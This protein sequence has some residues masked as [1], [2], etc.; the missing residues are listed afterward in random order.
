[1]SRTAPS[2][3]QVDPSAPGNIIRIALA[4]ESVLTVGISAYYIFFPR[5]YLL[6]TLGTAS[7]QVTTTALQMTQQFGAVGVLT[8]AGVGL[9]VPNTKS[10]IELRQPLYRALLAFE[11]AFVPLLL[12]QGFMM[13]DGIPKDSM[14]STA[15]QFVPFVAWRIFTLGWKPEWFGRYLDGKKSE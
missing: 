12:W 11:L 9:F 1:M 8:G 13:A 7:A 14:V 15:L 4:V 2:P 10:V 6:R 3:G 5:H